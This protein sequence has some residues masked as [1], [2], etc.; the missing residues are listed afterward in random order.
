MSVQIIQTIVSYGKH[1][2][3]YAHAK[4]VL[5]VLLDRGDGS[6][7]VKGKKENFIVFQHQIIII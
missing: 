7:L 4:E 6:F 2:K 1:K 3:V 5:P